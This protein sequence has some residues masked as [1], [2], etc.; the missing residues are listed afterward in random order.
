[1]RDKFL[2]LP[3]QIDGKIEIV[4]PAKEAASPDPAALTEGDL[5]V[6]K[7]VRAADI[8]SLAALHAGLISLASGS[9]DRSR[10][11]ATA[12]VTAS[13]AIATIYAGLLAL[14]YSA[15][16]TELPSRALIA[17]IFFALA[18]A[19]ATAYMSYITASGSVADVDEEGGWALKAYNRVQFFV[20]YTRTIV[21]RRV[22]MLQAAVIALA[23]AVCG[24][25]WPFVSPGSTDVEPITPAS[26]VVMW[27]TPVPTP[28]NP[29]QAAIL[30]NAQVDQAVADAESR[31]EATDA[32]AQAEA[33]TEAQPSWMDSEVFFFGTVGVGLLLMTAV[34]Y[35]TWLATRS[36]AW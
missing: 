13:S 1:M 10:A 9:V 28:D 31:A 2:S 33:E 19:L 18:I 29:E 20:D 34:P 17:P 5:A 6:L 30:F 26:V 21:L 15:G 36:R 27:P 22:W 24:M 12:T 8:A 35:F 16:G 11:A 32:E 25:A 7:D 23:I 14:V 3:I 4:E